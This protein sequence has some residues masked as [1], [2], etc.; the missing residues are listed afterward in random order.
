MREQELRQKEIQ[1]VHA[2]DVVTYGEAMAM[3]VA[4]E[5]GDL[6]AVAHFTRRLAGA[7]TNVAIGLARL[8]LKV[9]WLSRVGDDSF[10]RFIRA[11]VQAEG[12]DCSRV[13]TV[14]GQTSAFQLKARAEKR[15]RPAGRI[16]PQGFRRQPA[17]ARAPST[18]PISCP[19]ATCTPRAWRRPCPPPAWRSPARPSTSCREHGRTVSFDPNLRPHA[20]AVASR[21]GRTDQPPS[22][23]GA[24]WVLPGL[25][26]GKILTGHDLPHDIAGFYLQQGARLVVIK[27]GAEGAYYRTADGDSGVVPGERVAQVVD[28]VGAGDGFAAGL[29]SALLEGLPLAQAVGRANRV[30]A[31]AIQVAGDMEGLPTPRPAR[32]AGPILNRTGETLVKKHVLV[33]KKLAEPLL[34]RLRAECEVTYFEAIDAGN[35]AAFADAIRGAHGLLG[36]SV[37]LDRELLDPGHRPAHHFHHIGGRRPVRRRVPARAG[38]PAGQYAPTC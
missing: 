28:T 10:G 13:V 32:R 25:G 8:G 3:F 17:G 38:H 26:E 7:E 31:F 29:V 34:A 12:V 1:G 4:E 23:P 36:A 20:V 37:R 22:P 33:Y 14:A 35:R 18:P 5:T 15:R 11:S 27:L 9:G 2:L 30:G 21:H 19:R 16:L 24:D 6:A